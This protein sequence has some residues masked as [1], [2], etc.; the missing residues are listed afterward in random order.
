MIKDTD[1]PTNTF[2]YVA[3]ITAPSGFLFILPV[4]NEGKLEE[5]IENISQQIKGITIK[6]MIITQTV[7]GEL[8]YRRIDNNQSSQMEILVSRYKIPPPKER[9]DYETEKIGSK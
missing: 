2:A 5:E 1:G 6:S 3:E 8:C 7:L 4:I 9:V